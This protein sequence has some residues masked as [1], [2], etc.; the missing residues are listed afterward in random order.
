MKYEVYTSLFGEDCINRI[1]NNEKYD[2]ILIDDEM[3]LMSGITLLKELNNLDN[4]KI[5]YK[6]VIKGDV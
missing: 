6:I 5:E 1:K 4:K 2:L 3:K